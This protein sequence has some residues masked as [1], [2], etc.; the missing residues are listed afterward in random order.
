MIFS[1]EGVVMCSIIFFLRT[2]H[3]SP[4]VDKL[5]VKAVEYGVLK[6]HIHYIV[7]IV[8]PLFF[9]ETGRGGEGGHFQHL[10]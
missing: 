3:S 4:C 1:Q 10:L 2:K 6:S 5:I 9:E 8:G 7:G